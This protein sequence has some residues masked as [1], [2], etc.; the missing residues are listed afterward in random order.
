MRLQHLKQIANGLSGDDPPWVA[1]KAAIFA[2]VERLHWRLWNGKAAD[3][4][5]SIDRVQAVLYHFKGEPGTQNSIAPLRKLWAA[6]HALAGQL[7]RA[8]PWR[9]ESWN[10]DHRRNGQFPDESPD[11]QM[12]A[13]AMVATRRRLTPSGSLRDL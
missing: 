13:D 7:R 12:S 10:R 1:A 5:I 11:E 2:E 6:L 3:A 4:R 9:I 8:A